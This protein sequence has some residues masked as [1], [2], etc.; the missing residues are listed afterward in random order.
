MN[1]LALEQRGEVLLVDCGVTFDDRGLGVDVVHP[2]FEALDPLPHRRALRHARARGPHRR[3]P[4]PASPL[5]HARLRARATRS[6]SFANEPRSTKCSHH[7]DLR[8]SPR[9]TSCGSGRSRS[10][11]SASR[12]RSPTRRPWPSAPT[13]GLVVHTGDFKFDEAPPDG[14]LFDVARFEAARRARA[15]ASSSA[16]RPTSMRAARPAA[17]KAWARR[18]SG[19]SRR[20]EARRRRRA[21]SRRTCTGCACWATSPAATGARSSRLGEACAPTRASHGRRRG[22]RAS[23]AGRPYLEWPSDLVWPADRARELPRSSIA[24]RRDRAPRAKTRGARAPGTGRAPVDGPRRRRRGRALEPRH[25]RQRGQRHARHRRPAPPRRPTR[26]VVVRPR[27][28]RERP[29][30]PRGAAAHDRAGAP[31]DLRPGPW[32]PPPPGPARRARARARR[33]RR[34]GARERRRGRARARGP[35]REER[36]ACTR[37][38]CTSS[39]SDRCQRASCTSACRSRPTARLM[40]WCRSTPTAGSPATSWS[41]RRGVLDE[42]AEAHL[43]ASARNEATTA[44]EELADG[45]PGGR[46]EE[47][48]IA[49]AARMAV[50][51]AFGRT[52]G[53]KPVTTVTVLRQ[54]R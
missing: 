29:R 36:G 35:A 28:P 45:A 27:R 19:S 9:A 23:D 43:L 13:R 32:H 33:R 1:C 10:S 16:I 50:R 52:L 31:A 41:P 24:R 5:R 34:G 53:F 20:A 12:T 51:R 7:V 4:L 42:T 8:A 14:E 48:A 3:H 30:P 15:F 17:R 46:P 49:E 47:G 38:G 2:D 44:V 54:T 18:S 39:R 25:P 22:R 40:W 21:C 37:G 6:G 26:V 11:R